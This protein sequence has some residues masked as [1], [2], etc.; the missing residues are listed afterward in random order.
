[1][2]LRPAFTYWITILVVV[3]KYCGKSTFSYQK[4]T[5]SYVL[6]KP[7]VDCLTHRLTP[8]TGVPLTG[9]YWPKAS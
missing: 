1:M 3:S 4:S 8:L 7:T 5:Y 6:A 9:V 2:N